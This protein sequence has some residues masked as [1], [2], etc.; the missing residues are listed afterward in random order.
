[1]FRELVSVRKQELEVIL[2]TRE[3]KIS[4]IMVQSQPGQI[5]CN[6][7][8]KKKKKTITKKDWWSGSRCRPY[9]CVPQTHKNTDR[10]KK[11]QFRSEY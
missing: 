9:V 10:G 6:T 4:R 2:A 8:L 11:I 1:M 3:A 5:V 7:Y